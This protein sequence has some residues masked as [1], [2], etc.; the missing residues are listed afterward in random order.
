MLKKKGKRYIIHRNGNIN[1]ELG[2]EPKSLR[3]QY[4]VQSETKN[5]KKKSKSY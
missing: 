3:T 2:D 4:Q 1:F 5:R